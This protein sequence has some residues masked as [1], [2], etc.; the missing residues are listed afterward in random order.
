MTSFVWQKY[1]NRCLHHYHF[2]VGSSFLSFFFWGLRSSTTSDHLV[3]LI[4]SLQ[5]ISSVRLPLYLK[6]DAFNTCI[7]FSPTDLCTD[8]YIP[9]IQYSMTA[10]FV[11]LVSGKQGVQENQCLTGEIYPI[12]NPVISYLHDLIIWNA[13]YEVCGS[14]WLLFYSQDH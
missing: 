14:Q 3:V 8:K 6:P 7:T 1:S 12:S 9:D 11:L 4:D 2:M 10:S 13:S 5:D